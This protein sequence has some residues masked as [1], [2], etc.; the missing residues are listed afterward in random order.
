MI[1]R[2]GMRLQSKEGLDDIAVDRF[3]YDQDEDDEE[4]TYLIDPYD[5]SSMHYRATVSANTRE[6][7]QMQ[8]AKRAQ[9]EGS[10]ASSQATATGPSATVLPRIP[11][12]D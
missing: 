4:P 8:A 5:I 7:A 12:P 11:G 10:V 9:L 3:K 6:Q 1:D 2:R